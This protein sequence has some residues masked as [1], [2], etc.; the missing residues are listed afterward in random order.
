MMTI[1]K[2]KIADMLMTTSEARRMPEIKHKSNEKTISSLNRKRF[3]FEILKNCSFVVM[4]VIYDIFLKKSTKKI[5]F[6]GLLE[7][8]F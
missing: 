3:V 5:I 6:S 7:K 4:F 2:K 1:T 8:I